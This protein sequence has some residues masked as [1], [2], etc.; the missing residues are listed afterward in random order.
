MAKSTVGEAL[1]MHPG[2]RLALDASGGA[3]G[4]SLREGP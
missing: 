1:L 4:A 2:T 3:A